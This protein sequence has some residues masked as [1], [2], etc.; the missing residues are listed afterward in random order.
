[1]K[2]EWLLEQIDIYCSEDANEM[3]AEEGSTIT[4]K[5]AYKDCL[6]FVIDEARGTLL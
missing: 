1:M 2:L 4:Y 3:A 5:D 6:E